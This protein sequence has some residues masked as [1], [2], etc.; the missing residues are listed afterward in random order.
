VR[1]NLRAGR[2]QIQDERDRKKQRRACA[3]KPEV[4]HGLLEIILTLGMEWPEHPLF[5]QHCPEMSMR[6][7][8]IVKT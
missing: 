3:L 2:E 8:D 4:D 6:V 5:L 1:R 7:N